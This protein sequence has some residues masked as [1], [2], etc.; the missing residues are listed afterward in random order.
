MDPHRGF[1]AFAALLC[2]ALLAGGCP[3]KKGPEPGPDERPPAE[4]GRWKTYDDEFIR[5]SHPPE[6]TAQALPAAENVQRGWAVHPGPDPVHGSIPLVGTITITEYLD[7]REKRPL[8][9]IV[10]EGRWGAQRPIGTPKKLRLGDAGCL[11]FTREGRISA[12]CGAA[13]APGRRDAC[14]G[15]SLELLCYRSTGNHIRA[16][17]QL[18]NYHDKGKP[19]EDTKKTA[20]VVERVFRSIR[21]K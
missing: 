15:S 10:R 8:E 5:F 17:A 6:M 4:K 13:P 3:D 14:I 12:D 2:G 9:R 16:G 21:F 7:A 11:A 18:G 19:D 1:S 20:A